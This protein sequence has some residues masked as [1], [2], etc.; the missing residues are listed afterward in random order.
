MTD[1]TPPVTELLHLAAD[2]DA[3]AASE[4]FSLL[5][6]ELRR[7]AASQRARLPA[8]ET[9]GTTAIVHEAYLR[10]VGKL[11]V[12]WADRHHFFCTA[13]RS[14][15]DLLVDEA[16]RRSS[17]KRGGD[18]KRADPDELERVVTASP[19]DVI[20]LDLALQKLERE[21]EDD[22]RIV[23]LRYFAGLTVPETAGVL[24]IP[25][26]TVERRWRF[27]RS[28]LARELREEGAGG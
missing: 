12:P 19:E 14:M 16:R 20:A 18:L 1:P 21:D 9:L 28:W 27:C 2:G 11:D 6:G 26:R 5:Y 22:H 4:V 7:L 8:G 13:A 25:Q 17:A 10:M 15:R 23:M 24:G 3:G